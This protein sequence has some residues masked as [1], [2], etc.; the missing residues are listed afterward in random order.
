MTNEARNPNAERNH[1]SMF[2]FRHPDFFRHSSFVIRHSSF[3]I[4]PFPVLNPLW[5]L[6]YRLYRIYS[7]L[8]YRIVRRFTRAGMAVLGGLFAAVFLAPDTDNNVLYQALTPLLFLLLVATAFSLFFRA[9]FSAQRMLPRF[10]TVGSPLSY[11]VAI[12]TCSS[13]IQSGLV[14]LENLADP[15]PSFQ[16]W[17]AAQLADQN[18]IRVSQHR[19][20]YPFRLATPKPAAVPPAPPNQEVEVHAELTPL[21]RGILRFTGVT[22]ARPDPLGLFR[23]FVTV[24]LPQT[25]LILPRRYAL[26]PMALPGRMKHQER[27]VTLASSV[28]QSDQFIGLRDYRHGDPMR[29]I[30][31]RSWAKAGK[32]V[33]KEF[34]DEFF[35]R[36]ALV[37]D[38]FVRR[39]QSEVFEEAV[40]VAASFACVVRTQ[41]SL[42]D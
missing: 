2:G 26:P 27:G 22:L 7:W 28:G 33:V 8:R 21:C 37:L 14:L 34:E 36:H 29:H 20:T 24:P 39:Q 4:W 5:R 9:R 15:R 35:V 10:G 31:W 18:Q 38:T 23:G 41:E 17:H 25:T 32:P 19:R 16:D 11:S 42:L 30:H 12:T 3:L 6:L 13:K 1:P 40:S